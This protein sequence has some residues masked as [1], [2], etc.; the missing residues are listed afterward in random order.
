MRPHH[1]SR[2]L[3]SVAMRSFVLTLT[4]SSVLSCAGVSPWL[5]RSSCPIVPVSSDE[6]PASTR[7]RAQVRI[8]VGNRVIGLEVIARKLPD[9]LVVAGLAPHGTRL[10]G[11]RQRGREIEVEAPSSRQI[12][13][14]ALWVMDALHRGLWIEP[15]DVL[16][17][18][19][20]TSWTWEG[21]HVFEIQRN[22]RRH[23]EFRRTTKT[24]NAAPVTIAYRDFADTGAAAGFEILNAWC[25]YE[26]VIVPLAEAD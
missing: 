20:G 1:S 16:P 26:A 7:L 18:E 2:D 21:E 9:Q 11:V 12:E 24:N 17:R 3:G 8:G 4:L 5:E 25:G 15:V 19:D 22:G 6:L 23:R 13:R 14:L 10:F